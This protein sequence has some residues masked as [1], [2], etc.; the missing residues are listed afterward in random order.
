MNAF[1]QVVIDIWTFEKLEHKTS[2]QCDKNMDTDMDDWG[3][4]NSS[5]N[6]VQAS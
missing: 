3:D 4:Y 6:F 2:T 1:W 5:L